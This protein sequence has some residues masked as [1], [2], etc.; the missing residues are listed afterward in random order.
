M[1]EKLIYKDGTYLD[2]NPSWHS[3]D[4]PWKAKHILNILKK[5]NLLPQSICEVGCGVGEI[6]RLMHSQMADDVTFY[7]YDISPQAHQIAI[8]KKKPRLDFLLKDLLTEERKFDLVLIIDV[9][10]H[11]SDY[12]GFLAKIRE[13]AD[14]Q[15]FHIPLDLSVQTVLRAKPISDV[16]KSVGHIHFFTKEMALA[17][18][19]DLGYTILDYSYTAGMVELPGKR[20]ETHLLNVLRR[21]MFKVSPNLTSRILGGYSL[22]VLT[23]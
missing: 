15:V 12:Y 2:S 3:E 7:G 16:R 18:L 1:E 4:S 17:A 5:N 23:K 6:L 13:K 9:I 19:Q 20:F 8:K 22:M 21:V 14:F 10:E 11:V